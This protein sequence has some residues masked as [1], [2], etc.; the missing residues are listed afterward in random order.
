MVEFS[1]MVINCSKRLSIKVRS[2]ELRL[3]NDDL[4]VTMYTPAFTTQG[5]ST[6]QRLIMLNLADVINNIFRIF[7]RI[8]AEVLSSSA[9]APPGY[10]LLYVVYKEVPSMATWVQIK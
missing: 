8:T 4:Q 5:V 7:H 6:N 3:N 1:D 9:V 2:N 10:Y